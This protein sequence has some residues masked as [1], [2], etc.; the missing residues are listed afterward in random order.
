MDVA[1]HEFR[2][3]SGVGF[4]MC[5]ILFELWNFTNVD[6]VLGLGSGMRRHP[7]RVLDFR[8]C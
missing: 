2:F 6:F 8:M 7:F 5:D 1:S 3:G 4:R